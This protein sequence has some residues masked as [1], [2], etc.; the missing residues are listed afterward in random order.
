MAVKLVEMWGLKTVD[1]KAVLRA[2]GSAALTV[3]LRAV[4]MAVYSADWS[5][6]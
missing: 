2:G 5:A 3:Q 4:S 6:H 1:A